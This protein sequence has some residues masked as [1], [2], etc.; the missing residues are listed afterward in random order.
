MVR[1]KRN[2]RTINA[3]DGWTLL[4]VECFLRASC[5][6]CVY[7]RYC[8]PECHKERPILKEVCS[9]LLETVGYPSQRMIDK[10][11]GKDLF[12]ECDFE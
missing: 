8:R 3:G 5:N 2:G 12:G 10:A 7:K 11:T 1:V 9:I 6:G 4:S